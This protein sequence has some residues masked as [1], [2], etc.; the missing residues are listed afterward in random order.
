MV[1]A[2]GAEKKKS[3]GTRQRGEPHLL[4]AGHPG[5]GKSQLLKFVSKLNPRSVWVTGTTATTAGL[6][7]GRQLRVPP[8][9]P[10]SSLQTGS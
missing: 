8:L 3:D 9:T 4:L 7:T 10:G 6:H 2:G 1:L 5:T